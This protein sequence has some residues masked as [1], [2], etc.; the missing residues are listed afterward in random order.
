MIWLDTWRGLLIPFIFLSPIQEKSSVVY[1]CIQSLDNMSRSH[2]YQLCRFGYFMATSLKSKF[3]NKDHTWVHNNLISSWVS[4]VSYVAAKCLL[5]LSRANGKRM[6]VTNDIGVV[7]PSMSRTMQCWNIRNQG[8]TISKG[9]SITKKK[10]KALR[11][12][13]F[14]DIEPTEEVMRVG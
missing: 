1:V 6:S 13:D 4:S 14:S 10:G 8:T 5:T 11:V 12:L 7:V 3:L 9:S 2:G